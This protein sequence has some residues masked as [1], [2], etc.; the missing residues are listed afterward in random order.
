MGIRAKILLPLLLGFFGLAAV[1]HFVW[2]PALLD[3]EKE[4]LSDNAHQVMKMLV[5]SLTTTLLAGDFAELYSLLND[6]KERFPNLS[7]ITLINADGKRLYPFKEHAVEVGK[8]DVK[9]ELEISWDGTAL[10]KLSTVLNIEADIKQEQHHILQLEYYT[11]ATFGFIALVSAIWLNIAVRRPIIHLQNAA[12]LLSQGDFNVDLKTRSRAKDELSA[13]SDA[14]IKM[15]TNLRSAHTDLNEAAVTAHNNEIRQRAIL[16]N[17]TDGIVIFD[18]NKEIISLNPAAEHIFGYKLNELLQE[19]I[20]VLLADDYDIEQL[21]TSQN[22]SANLH[23]EVSG[24]KKDESIF[25]LEISTNK[26]IFEEDELFISI[27][28][29]ISERK[30]VDKMKSEFVSTVSHELRTPLTSIRGALGL[31]KGGI[32]G[33]LSPELGKLI[34][35]ACNNTERLLL[36]VNDIL[37]I[38]KIE[39]GEMEFNLIDIDAS[40]LLVQAVDEYA[41]FAEQCGVKFS[42][43][44]TQKGIYIHGDHLRLMQVIGNLLSN[45]AKFSPK[46]GTVEIGS[47]IVEDSLQ[48]FVSDKGAGIPSSYLPRLFD[49]FTQADSS[50]TRSVN[51]TGLGLPITKALVEKHG[52]QI[53]VETKEGEGTTFYITFPLC[54]TKFTAI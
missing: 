38:Q 9:K 30:R 26:L 20:Q 23:V 46:G 24:I 19:N 27:I 49:K 37:D 35:L 34:K 14:F 18:H 12:T 42:I 44:A 53:S 1:V 33:E 39:A 8:Y 4:H 28:R 47:Q 41:G 54:N 15:K 52:G 45:A 32:V 6:T 13:L 43:T 50:D 51:G 48:I 40:Q 3:R 17:I 36:L 10:G 29:D 22:D 21:T 31:V 2:G 25:P 11:L 16:N 7:Q 5:P